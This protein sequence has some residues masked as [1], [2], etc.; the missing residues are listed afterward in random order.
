MEHGRTEE[1]SKT[2][3]R[4][5]RRSGLGR[6]A[7]DLGIRPRWG[8]E[9]HF[10]FEMK[11]V[12]GRDRRQ[13]PGK[14]RRKDE[15]IATRAKRAGCDRLFDRD[16]IPR[17]SLSFARASQARSELKKFDSDEAEESVGTQTIWSILIKS[18]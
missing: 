17:R 3:T 15:K 13:T 5:D 9:E 10:W 18:H 1:W 6:P 2:L 8:T 11:Q 4:A 16:I 12:S 7:Q 14:E